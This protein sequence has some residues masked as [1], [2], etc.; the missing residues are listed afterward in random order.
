MGPGKAWPHNTRPCFAETTRGLL[1]SL[2]LLLQSSFRRSSG[3]VDWWV[4]CGSRTDDGARPGLGEAKRGTRWRPRRWG[5]GQSG[6]TRT[7][8]RALSE[9]TTTTTSSSQ[10]TIRFQVSTHCFLPCLQ[11]PVPRRARYFPAGAVQP[12]ERH[13]KSPARAEEGAHGT[14][15]QGSSLPVSGRLDPEFTAVRASLFH[16]R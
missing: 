10:F 14:A 9:S 6:K 8:C 16:S 3:A 4:W 1:V 13:E 5:A 11:V 7:P 15:R 12:K 2:V